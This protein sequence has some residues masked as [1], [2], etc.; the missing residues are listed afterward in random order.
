MFL[1]LICFILHLGNA[2][3]EQM[4]EKRLTINGSFVPEG[5][6]YDGRTSSVFVSSIDFTGAT[7]SIIRRYP[8]TFNETLFNANYDSIARVITHPDPWF[9]S[10]GLDI[11]YGNTGTPFIVAAV[12]NFFGD[13]TGAQ[14]CGISISNALTG[15]VEVI[16]LTSLSRSEPSLPCFTNDIAVNTATG[17]MFITDFFG[18][19][20]FAIRYSLS[21]DGGITILGSPFLVSD[22]MSLL[23]SSADS[24]NGPNGCEYLPKIGGNGYM[25]IAVSPNKLVRMSIVDP[26]AID[27]TANQFATASNINIDYPDQINGLD[28][29]ILESISGGDSWMLHAASGFPAN[30]TVLR[31]Y[32]D[33]NNADVLTRVS[34]FA[35]V[36]PGQVPACTT[37]ARLDDTNEFMPICNND[38]GSGPYDAPVYTSK[39][40]LMRPSRSPSISINQFSQ[41][42]FAMSYDAVLGNVLVASL[43]SNG[44]IGIPGRTLSTQND[45]TIIG[46]LDSSD[47][48]EYLPA[49]S[50]SGVCSQIIDMNVDPEN[51]C[52]LWLL[53]PSVGYSPEGDFIYL[54]GAGST[55]LGLIN[56]CGT[57]PGDLS[58]KTLPLQF[59]DTNMIVPTSFVIN[60]DKVDG[61]GEIFI[62]ANDASGGIVYKVEDIY[63]DNPEFESVSGD[64]GRFISGVEIFDDQL[65]VG[66]D[67]GIRIK[68]IDTN[69]EVRIFLDGPNPVEN[70]VSLRFNSDKSF[71]FMT[72]FDEVIVLTS[73]DQWMNETDVS[74]RIQIECNRGSTFENPL[75]PP[76]AD[77]FSRVVSIPSNNQESHTSPWGEN[78][79]MLCS[80]E[81]YIG[82]PTNNQIDMHVIDQYMPTLTNTF[83]ASPSMLPGCEDGEDGED[84]VDEDTFIAV[85]SLA[86]IF[87]ATT[88]GLIGYMTCNQMNT[89]REPSMR[90]NQAP[91]SD[92]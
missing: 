15:A 13:T 70:A 56:L 73:R 41:G 29:V 2:I 46:S 16:D 75:T 57:A 4:M 42:N 92:M 65:I 67:D 71:L 5:I 18:Y 45:P 77:Y 89:K 53:C 64:W 17:H 60:S 8:V 59:F 44:I 39:L 43:F 31:L 35:S 9:I 23:K 48:I 51:H 76:A 33:S 26:N 90:M 28:G 84:D 24:L 79:V 55:N 19:Q 12:N 63:G 88:F 37:I 21:T 25:V 14:K 32:N 36:T 1:V 83:N 38:F 81:G 7:A 68:D 85:A 87:G 78:L 30:V 62:V 11:I 66:A 72:T 6:V 86:A 40:S 50:G 58:I 91:R 34:P 61:D 49:T 22:D 69:G 3:Q 20:V 27:N 52:M 10:V 54:T 80:A 82:Q 74:A 47:Y